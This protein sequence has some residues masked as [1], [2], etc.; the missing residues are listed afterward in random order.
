MLT[1]FL[2]ACGSEAETRVFTTEADGASITLEYTFEDDRVL[3][4][5]AK[6]E[7]TYEALGFDSKKQAEDALKEATK[8][9]ENV[10]GITYKVDFNEEE[11]IEQTNIVFEEI[12]FEKAKD[13]PGLL[14]EGDPADGISMEE[15]AKLL[16]ENGFTEKE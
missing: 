3:S 14:F 13:L 11:V 15:S 6:S 5:A 10:D 1:L 7:M 8:Q 12:D 16:L 4:Q 9:Y 2:T